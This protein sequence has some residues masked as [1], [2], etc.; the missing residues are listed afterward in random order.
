MIG[1]IADQELVSMSQLM[2]NGVLDFLFRCPEAIVV[3]D[4]DYNVG[5]QFG[6]CRTNIL[7]VTT[8]GPHP[9]VD[10]ERN[11]AQTL[12][13][14]TI[15]MRTICQESDDLFDHTVEDGLIERLH[16][17]I[18]WAFVVCQVTDRHPPS[19]PNP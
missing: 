14:K 9:I 3:I 17:C 18:L 6:V 5:N 8:L 1:V 13:G 10:G 4:F 19:F 15:S 7:T 2:R 12:D 16:G 11:S